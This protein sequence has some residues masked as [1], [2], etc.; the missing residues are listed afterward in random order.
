MQ[1]T[2]STA[3]KRRQ[4]LLRAR[5]ELATFLRALLFSSAADMGEPTKETPEEMHER[6]TRVHAQV[7][8]TFAGIVRLFP[9]AS[10]RSSR[11]ANIPVA[12]QGVS[13]ATVEGNSGEGSD[14]EALQASAQQMNECLQELWIDGRFWKHPLEQHPQDSSLWTAWCKLVSA[15]A[16]HQ[17]E[18]LSPATD[19]LAFLV[20][21][22]LNN[23][24]SSCQDAAWTAAL[25]FTSACP[26][27]LKNDA[28]FEKL[29]IDVSKQMES[30]RVS[31]AMVSGLLPL[32]LQ[33]VKHGPEEHGHGRLQALWLPAALKGFRKSAGGR[34]GEECAQVLAEVLLV[35]VMHQTT[36]N[37]SETQEIAESWLKEVL[38]H[39]HSDEFGCGLWKGVRFA[40]AFRIFLLGFI[41]S[42]MAGEM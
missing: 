18:F 40:H 26:G 12:S 1:A 21:D 42:G 34:R 4:A 8:L 10:S 28:V 7:L 5:K 31:A 29:M 37:A 3:E 35:L 33:V 22:A 20:Y 17:P 39:P 24:P 2:F 36:V 41:W 16:V 25:C 13:S 38:V 27:V 15:L 11:E 6:A 19:V 9:T 14:S 23:A 32:G 30:G